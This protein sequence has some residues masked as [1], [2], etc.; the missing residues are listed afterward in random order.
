MLVMRSPV[1]SSEEESRIDSRKRGALFVCLAL[2]LAAGLSC[3]KREA[4]P[5]V[6]ATP[7]SALPQTS[8]TPSPVVDDSPDL[9]RLA[10][11]RSVVP[12]HAGPGITPPVAIYREP[13]DWA[14]LQAIRPR[15]TPIYEEV[16]GADGSVQSV[17]VIRSAGTEA[18]RIL[19]S[20]L[21]RWR[22]K[23]ALKDG[24]PIAAYFTVTLNIDY[25]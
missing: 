21:R 22:F 17:K 25:Q 9:K 14:K 8:D 10:V 4:V 1:R 24:K 2:A 20:D 5:A 12:V 19:I 18:D 13:L 6:E 23:P 3:T 15:P 7:V 16:I 11:P